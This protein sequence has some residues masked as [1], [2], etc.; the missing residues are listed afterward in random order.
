VNDPRMTP[1]R[2][3]RFAMAWLRCD[4]DELRDFLTADAVYSPLSGELVRGREAVVRRFAKTL[5]D[6]G[7]SEIRFEPATV[8]GSLGACRWRM[9]VHT[10]DGAS[11]E[12]EGLDLYEFD[13]ERIRFKD[14]YQKA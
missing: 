8:S 13:G 5:A 9:S 3:D 12:V 7:G 14:V 4:L 2:L 6:D 11:F 1:E 10:A